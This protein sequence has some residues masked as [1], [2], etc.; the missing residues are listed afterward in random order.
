EDYYVEKAEN[1]EEALE[2]ANNT[3]LKPDL[4]ILDVMM[5]KIDG[6]QVCKKLKSSEKTRDIPIIMLTVKNTPEDLKKAISYNV[7][8]F[9]T[10]PF[11]PE[12]LEK[13]VNSYFSKERQKGKLSRMG[14]SIHYIKDQDS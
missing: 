4:I 5:P 11:E 13:R 8:E 3:A 2:K 6:F 14:R 7:D 1:G 10:K 12:I 9:I